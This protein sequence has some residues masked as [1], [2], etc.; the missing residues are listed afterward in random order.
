MDPSFSAALWSSRFMTLSTLYMKMCAGSHYWAAST[1]CA[2]SLIGAGSFM[3]TG[4]KVCGPR[5]T[6]E[7]AC[8]NEPSVFWCSACLAALPRIQSGGALLFGEPS[9]RCVHF[10][11][12]SAVLKHDAWCMIIAKNKQGKCFPLHA[13]DGNVSVGIQNWLQQAMWFQCWVFQVP[14][15]KHTFEETSCESHSKWFEST[16]N[17]STDD[18]LDSLEAALS[19]FGNKSETMKY[20]FDSSLSPN[21]DYLTGLLCTKTVYCPWVPSQAP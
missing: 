10:N 4:Q 5:A 14:P 7:T 17:C 11:E 8:V 6:L 13:A 2:R 16:W 20:N 15:I 3:S 1:H 12:G 9:M 19:P 18:S 21:A